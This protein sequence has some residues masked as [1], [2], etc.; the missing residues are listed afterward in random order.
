MRAVECR[1]RQ[2]ERDSYCKGLCAT[3]YYRVLRTGE[4]SEE[5]PI[6]P[7]RGRR[8]SK[9]DR[10]SWATGMKGCSSCAEILPLDLFGEDPSAYLGVA[11][12][13]KE[14]RRD[15]A[16]KKY[17]SL[18][19]RRV[20]LDRARGRARRSGIRF[21]LTIEDIEVPETCPI[22]G[23]P[24]SRGSGVHSD[25]SPSLDRVVPSLG[26]VK[27][28]VKVISNRANRIKSD[29]TPDELL[30]IHEYLTSGI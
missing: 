30:A 21:S 14:C 20:I 10:M 5:T 16:R 9:S 22:L 2:C 11:Q 4:L 24:L 8:F 1:A 27:G 13:C 18:D 23:I 12:A 7:V 28:N 25:N 29:A 17:A 19:H 15:Q 3:H 6:R 26:Y